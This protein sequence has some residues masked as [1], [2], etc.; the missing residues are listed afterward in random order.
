M[1][2]K[3]WG[4]RGS[5]ARAGKSHIWAGGN[6]SCVEITD[7]NDRLILDAGTGLK[8]LGDTLK[9]GSHHIVLSHFHTDHICGLPFFVPF[10]SQSTVHIYAPV[11]KKESPKH[12]LKQFFS[13][14]FFPVPFE[15]LPAKILVTSVTEKTFTVGPF[16]IKPFVANHPG[17]TRGYLIECAGKKVAYF[18]DHEPIHCVNHLKI[19]NPKTYQKKLHELIQGADLL[20]HDAHFFDSEYKKYKGWGHSSWD[21]AITL[22]KEC[23]IK[24]LALFHHAPSHEDVIIKKNYSLLKSQKQKIIL[25]RDGLT[26]KI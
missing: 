25:A 16:K 19:S 17:S 1:N 12:I 9:T 5:L 15:K 4:V 21:Y 24:T 2:V 20:I 18:S 13:P 8:N 26:L 11:Q 22:A 6:T 14:A 23:D 7:K 10:Y 3:F